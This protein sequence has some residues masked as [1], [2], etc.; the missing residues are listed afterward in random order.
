M[1]ELGL[2][3]RKIRIDEGSFMIEK[4]KKKFYLDSGLNP[5]SY[6]IEERNDAQFIVEEF[7]LL[8]N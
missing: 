1:K 5:I 2:N 8:A 3:R 6:K 4:K 7:M